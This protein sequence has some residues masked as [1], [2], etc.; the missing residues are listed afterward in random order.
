MAGLSQAYREE[1]LVSDTNDVPFFDRDGDH[2]ITI[3]MPFD[4]DGRPP[5]TVELAGGPEN[6]P[7]MRCTFR[8]EHRPDADPAWV[9]VEV[10]RTWRGE[11]V[12]GSGEALQRLR[13]SHP[14]PPLT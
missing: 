12:P 9:Y 10:S 13:E 6:G 3:E 8:R 11:P 5:E 7:G 4:E 1:A 14:W 2:W